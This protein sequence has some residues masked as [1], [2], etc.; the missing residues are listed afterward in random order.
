MNQ[1]KRITRRLGFDIVRYPPKSA[2]TS[3]YDDIDIDSVDRE[4]IEAVRPYTMTSKERILSVQQAVRYIV[5]YDIQ[6]AIV[7]CGVWKGGCIMAAM[8]VLSN[9]NATDRDLFLFDTF[10]G[11]P[12]PRP[13]D[14]EINGKSAAQLMS[15]HAHPM[16][17][18]ILAR[19]GIDEVRSNVLQTR[20][21]QEHIRFVQGRV[22]VTIPE[23][24]PEQ[25]ALLRLDTDWYESTRH[26]LMHLFPRLVPGGVLI[27]DDYGHWKG[28]RKAVDEYFAQYKHPIFLHRID[29]TGRIAIK[30]P[31]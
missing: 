28:A 5:Q 27:I 31:E 11:M 4:I 29:Y 14:V 6:G 3:S 17:E 18:C 25:I 9:L 13:E 26:E 7:E 8:Y 2:Q 24:A 21:P 19:A 10:E 20:Y 22:E 30:L 23:H 1:I 12:P 15:D 16:I